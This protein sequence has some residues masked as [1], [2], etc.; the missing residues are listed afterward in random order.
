M[1]KI[2]NKILKDLY[3]SVDGLY[4]F[5]FYSRYSIRA[6]DMFKIINKYTERGVLTYNNDRLCVTHEGRSMI[7]KQKFQNERGGK[8]NNIPKEFLT[9]KLE[10][11]SPYVPNILYVSKEIL[12]NKKVG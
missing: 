11:N 8:Y 6:E 3:E 1:K 5:T 2:E 7:L 9:E 4:A 12:K 10:I